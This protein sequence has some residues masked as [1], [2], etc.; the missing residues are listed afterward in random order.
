[1]R[2]NENTKPAFL[3]SVTRHWSSTTSLRSVLDPFCFPVLQLFLILFRLAST[4]TAQY[5][6]LCPAF[7][8]KKKKRQ[9]FLIKHVFGMYFSLPASAMDLFILIRMKACALPALVRRDQ[10]GFRV[11][12]FHL[13]CNH[14]SVFE[15][16][17]FNNTFFT[18]ACIRTS[19]SGTGCALKKI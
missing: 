16:K 6:T 19:K 14:R 15:I 4:V 13:N 3:P 12:C 5:F 17:R 8:K 10:V 2:I 9:D 1:M 7:Y 18:L 11:M